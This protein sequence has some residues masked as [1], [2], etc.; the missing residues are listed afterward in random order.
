MT[1][2]ERIDLI[3]LVKQQLVKEQIQHLQLSHLK[4]DFYR[5][6]NKERIKLTKEELELIDSIVKQII[7]LRIGKII[8]LIDQ[9]SIKNFKDLLADEECLFWERI[10]NAQ[11]ELKKTTLHEVIEQ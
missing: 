8:L 5:I 6:V 1:V 10:N 2:E 3:L 7:R 11:E 9:D 4:P